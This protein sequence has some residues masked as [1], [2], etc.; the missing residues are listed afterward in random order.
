MKERERHKNMANLK[1]GKRNRTSEGKHERRVPPLLLHK[2]AR[3]L[4]TRFAASFPFQS[5]KASD[6]DAAALALQGNIEK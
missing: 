3:K 5:A 6:A 1:R 2:R 4:A